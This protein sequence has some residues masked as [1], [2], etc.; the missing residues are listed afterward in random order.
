[1]KK[2]W[3]KWL[4][5][6]LLL[7]IIWV[8]V[9]PAPKPTPSTRLEIEI[10]GGFAYVPTPAQNLLEV[11]YLN[12]VAMK[13][14]AGATICEVDQIG[15]ELMVERADI[16]TADPMAAPANKK[17]NLDKA[18]V[19]FPALETAGLP[20]SISKGAWPP[21]QVKPGNPDDDGE[22]KD[23]KY[24]PGLKDYHSGSSLRPDWRS[25]V[26]GRVVLKGGTIVGTRPS[27]PVIKKA[28]FDFKASGVSKFMGAITDKTIYVVQVPGNEVEILLSNATSGYTRFVVKPSASYPAAVRL[29]LKGLHA[30]STS[31]SLTGG[32]PLNDF[33]S[34]Y[35]LLQPVPNVADW[36]VPHYVALPATTAGGQ[37]SPGFFCP[38]DWF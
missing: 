29:T 28:H 36:L 32:Q 15:T 7:I 34:F 22:W 18:V 35:E 37:P 23:M 27:D 10:T 26:N 6:V 21:S 14:G 33:C 24:V 12:D 38:G 9:K 2:H 13:D 5:M 11:A 17:F 20:L 31:G 30:M 3:W 25:V 16:V 19:T 8:V 1:M 4:V